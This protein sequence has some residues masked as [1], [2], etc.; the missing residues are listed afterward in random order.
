MHLQWITFSWSVILMVALSALGIFIALITF[1][2][3]GGVRSFS[4]LSNFD[5]AITV[6]FGSIIAN[7]LTTNSPIFLQAVFALAFLFILQLSVARL[8]RTTTFIKK[9]VDN[10]PLLLMDGKTFLQ[11][12]LKKGKVTEK[13]VRSKLRQNGVTKYSQIRA[14]VME[15]TGD[16]SVLQMSDDGQEIDSAL[17]EDVRGWDVK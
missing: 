14:V 2:K 9:L 15:T 13:D 6:A 12:N 17:L 11:N 5:F 7:T 8:R 4:K 10:E 16:I 3:I 1:T